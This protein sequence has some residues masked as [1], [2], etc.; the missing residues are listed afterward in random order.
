MSTAPAVSSKRL[1]A[2]DAL[3]VGLREV[4]AEE[5]QTLWERAS[6]R[7]D[8][9]WERSGPHGGTDQRCPGQNDP[10][11][12]SI[13]AEWT[14]AHNLEAKW[15]TQRLANA[16]GRWWDRTDY[17]E[18]S[19]PRRWW[20]IDE[21]SQWHACATDVVVNELLFQ[22]RELSDAA[23]GDLRADPRVETL[24]EF[25]TRAEEHY[26]VRAAA[27]ACAF[28]P[29]H[30]SNLDRDARWLLRHRVRGESWASIAK[31]EQAGIRGLEERVRMA[32]KRLA[33][34]VDLL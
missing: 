32:I 15:L 18:R 9:L 7:R 19:D 28:H 14:R 21:R 25:V 10:V 16:I 12:V 27:I 26:R 6:R 20:T 29:P 1:A 4:C 31:S 30:G 11:F 23:W 33:A 34:D 3:F 13:A 8:V 2:R 5:V 17:F 22:R 24:K